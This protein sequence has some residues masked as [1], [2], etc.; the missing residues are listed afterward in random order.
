ML[1]TKN[2]VGV[3]FFVLVSSLVGCSEREAEVVELEYEIYDQSLRHT[4]EKELDARGVKY[5]V[6]GGIIF[7]KSSDVHKVNSAE[8][9]LLKE[10]L[11]NQYSISYVKDEDRD[12]FVRELEN[13]GISYKIITQL[14]EVWVVWDKED[15]D[16]VQAIKTK[17]NEVISK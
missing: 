6:D 17:V 3:L 5:R 8:Q 12:L 7:Y 9:Y 13:T 1:V 16:Q 10:V 15:D 2:L 11:V 4:F 14:G